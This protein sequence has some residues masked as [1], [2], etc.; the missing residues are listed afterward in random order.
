MNCAKTVTMST[1]ERD[2]LEILGRVAARASASGSRSTAAITPVRGPRISMHAAR[3]R[4]RRDES[5]DGASRR[6]LGVALRLLRLD[7]DLPRA[8]RQAGRLLHRQSQHLPRSVRRDQEAGRDHALRSRTRDQRAEAGNACPPGFLADYNER[9]AS[10]RPSPHDA[11]RSVRD[12]EDLA[13]LSTWK[14]ERRRTRNL[15]LHSQRVIVLAEPGTETFPLAGE[16]LPCRV[17]FDTNPLVN[18]AVR[19]RNAGRASHRRDVSPRGDRA[20]PGDSA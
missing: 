13:L 8:A 6:G 12:D 4:R 18:G 14:G 17:F 16:L 20:R 19:E 11:H 1:R 9:F 7:P 5:P 3:V 15:T 10:E 2:R